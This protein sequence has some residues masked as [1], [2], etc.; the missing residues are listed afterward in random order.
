MKTRYII[1]YLLV[2]IIEGLL[3]AFYLL[4]MQFDPSRGQILNYTLLRWIFFG[5][6]AVILLGLSV[7]VYLFIRKHDL[8]EKFSSFLDSHLVSERKRLFPT[9]AALWVADIFLFECFLLTYIAFPLPT[10]PVF[11]WGIVFCL[12][13]WFFFRVVYAKEYR[14]RRKL[15]P[16]LRERWHSLLPVQRKVIIILAILGFIYFLLFIPGNLLRDAQTHF[17]IADDEN[18]IY[19]DVVT[20]LTTGSTFA[21]TVH[22]LIDTW[23]FWYG[24]PYLTICWLVLLIPRLIFGNGFGQNV[25]LN[26]FLLR[27]FVSVLPMI[28]CIILSVYLVTHF[29]NLWLSIGLFVFLAV[30]PGVIQYNHHF[31]HPDSII[32]LLLLLTFFFLEID[33]LRFKRFFY[34]AAVAIGLATAIK[35]WG[36]FF[37]LAIGGYLIAGIFKK[38]ASI[39]KAVL[40]GFLFILVMAGTILISSPTLMVPRITRGALV[41]WMDQQNA[42]L[43]GYNEPDPEGVYKTGLTTWLRFFGYYYMQAFFFF[44]A[45]IA[46]I[47]GS[48]L[49]SRKYLN[50]LLLGW[51]LASASFVIAFTAMKSSHYML[52]VMFPL[53]VGAALFPYLAGEAP[54][55]KWLA[56]LAKPITQKVLLGI[57]LAFFAVQLVINLGIDYRWVVRI[58]HSG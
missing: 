53:F 32:V 22:N 1:I 24:S 25:Q 33:N 34:F 54:K 11:L 47:T 12:Q 43:N 39:K 2:S 16:T 17:Y 4:S 44:F 38:I 58:L 27:Q 46:I 36:V 49:G 31:W 45:F 8:G 42:L 29:K 3:S 37:V 5:I 52:P 50:R 30:L 20:A 15:H 21:E 19:T 14:E 10:Q 41:G 28:L 48:F 40:L 6:F 23:Q 13:T 9:Q 26:I 57:T 55:V 7:L 35:L 18:V 51:S 56:F